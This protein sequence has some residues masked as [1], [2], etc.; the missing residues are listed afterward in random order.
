MAQEDSVLSIHVV[1]VLKKPKAATAYDRG[2]N[3][4]A[5][6]SSLGRAEC[7][8]HAR[9]DLAYQIINGVLDVDVGR[10]CRDPPRAVS[11]SLMR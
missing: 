7:V 5:R 6:Q 9:D 8:G 10:R 4:V 2:S 3:A 1:D 11:G